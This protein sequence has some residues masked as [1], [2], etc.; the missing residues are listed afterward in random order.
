MN[1]SNR[2]LNKNFQEIQTKTMS[3]PKKL[4]ISAY[5]EFLNKIVH[6]TYYK[7]V[8]IEKKKTIVGMIFSELRT[9]N[10]LKKNFL[11]EL[12]D[13]NRLFI[14]SENKE[15]LN[16][17]SK[18]FLKKYNEY[19]KNNRNN[20]YNQE[21]R[22]KNPS[23]TTKFNVNALKKLYQRV[24]D[25][26]AEFFQNNKNAQNAQFNKLKKNFTNLQQRTRDIIPAVKNTQYKIILNKLIDPNNSNYKKIRKQNKKSIIGQMYVNPP[27]LKNQTEKQNYLNK[28]NAL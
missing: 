8:S 27:G 18:E 26:S 25:K 28:V 15:Y 14:K 22:V 16:E 5:L 12:N 13:I 2:I 20:I 3:Y 24:L 17:Y 7:D 6:S 1:N 23:L 9:L 4:K 10:I 11:N 21:N 19:R